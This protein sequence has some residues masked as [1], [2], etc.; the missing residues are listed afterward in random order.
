MVVNPHH[1][2]ASLPLLETRLSQERCYPQ[3]RQGHWEGQAD[4]RSDRGDG[5]AQ[6]DPVLPIE[7][8]IARDRVKEGDK[9]A[10]SHEKSAAGY[11]IAALQKREAKRAE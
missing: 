7:G 2:P 9:V 3:R 4:S 6:D 8:R 5:M 1:R 10:F 11:V